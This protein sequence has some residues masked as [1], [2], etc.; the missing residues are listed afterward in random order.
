M[1]LLVDSSSPIYTGKG[2]SD[3]QLSR[4]MFATEVSYR[5]VIMSYAS[6][7]PQCDVGIFSA[8]VLR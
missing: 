5:I 8:R 6:D 1:D 2:V 3:Y 4:F 7:V